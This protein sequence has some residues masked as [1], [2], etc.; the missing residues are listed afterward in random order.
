MEINTDF[1][2]NSFNSMRICSK[3]SFVTSMNLIGL[4]NLKL[5]DPITFDSLSLFLMGIIIS[6]VFLAI[7]YFVYKVVHEAPHIHW[8]DNLFHYIATFYFWVTGASLKRKLNRSAARALD[9]Y[10]EPAVARNVV[11][12]DFSVPHYQK[13]GQTVKVRQYSRVNQVDNTL[14][15]YIHGGGFVFGLQSVYDET[16]RYFCSKGMSVISIDY[17]LAPENPFPEGVHDCF[18]VLKWIKENH[19]DKKIVIAGDSAGG[20]L[21]AVMCLMNRN[22]KLNLNISLQILI[23]PTFFCAVNDKKDYPVLSCD[24]REF[25]VASYLKNPDDIHSELVNPMVSK[26]G[27]RHLP[28]CVLISAEYDVLNTDAN[29]WEKKFKED[30]GSIVR[31]HYP[32]VHGFFCIRFLKYVREARN[33]VVKEIQE[34]KL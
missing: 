2:I 5:S 14:M 4:L 9:M 12:K 11:S 6:V 18:S 26:D 30:G 25:T 16:C 24:A 15:I 33:A 17:C 7:P 13:E 29:E 20:N 10:P 8:R 22:S 31:F 34:A 27:L 19:K 28:K 3:F 32:T 23:Y 21:C 1:G